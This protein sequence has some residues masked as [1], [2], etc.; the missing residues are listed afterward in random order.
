[1]KTPYLAIAA[2]LLELDFAI[3]ESF[4]SPA[5]PRLLVCLWDNLALLLLALHG[6]I[7]LAKFLLLAIMFG[8]CGR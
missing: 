6:I 4:V 8:V 7:W 2:T 5:L 1:M 3:W